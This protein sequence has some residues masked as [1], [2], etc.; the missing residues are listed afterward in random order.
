MDVA[1]VKFG[2]VQ[3][4]TGKISRLAPDGAVRPIDLPGKVVFQL[5]RAKIFEF[6][7]LQDK[8]FSKAGNEQFYQC[9]S[10]VL[11]SFRS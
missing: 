4:T 7:P 6:K 2:T 9:F 11:I 10:F 5:F 1:K 8:D 3:I